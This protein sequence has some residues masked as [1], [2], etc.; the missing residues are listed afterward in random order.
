MCG[1]T[2]I[3]R[4]TRTHAPPRD[5][6]HGST[7][8]AFSQKCSG[9]SSEPWQEREKKKRK[10]CES[11]ILAPVGT[12]TPTSDEDISPFFFLCFIFHWKKSSNVFA[13]WETYKVSWNFYLVFIIDKYKVGWN[14]YSVF[15]IDFCSCIHKAVALDDGCVLGSE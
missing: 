7:F 4:K 2:Q 6:T 13:N 3:D 11:G 12:I 8:R 14:F 15:I 1:K 10:N 5:S 9:A